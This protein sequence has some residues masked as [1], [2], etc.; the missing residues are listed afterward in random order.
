M[1]SNESA[2][3]HASK[4]N[5]RAAAVQ[6]AHNWREARSEQAERQ[7]FWNAFFQIFGVDRRQVAAFER[8]AERASTGN[9]GWI[10]MLNPGQMAVEHKSAGEDLDDAMG[11]L[12]DYLPSLTKAEMPWLLVVCDFQRF[13]WENLDTGEQGQFSL[14][15]LPEHLDLF[16]WIGGYNRPHQQFGSDEEANLAATQ[17]LANVHD[18]LAE[19]GYPAED[20]REWMTRVLFVLFADDSGVWDRAAFHTYIALH[21]KPDGSDLGQ[22]IA[23]IFE[24]LNTPPDRRQKNLD[25]DLAALTYVNGDI[26]AKRL[27][28]PICDKDTRDALLWAS[29][30]NWSVISPAIFGSLFQNVMEP[31]ERRQLGAHYTTEENILRTIRPLFLDALEAD[32]RAAKTK[33]ALRRFVDRLGEIHMLDPACGCGNFLVIAYRELRRLETEALRR[34]RQRDR[35]DQHQ[36]QTDVTLDLRVTVDQ[37]SGIELEE[38]P[39][40]IARTA[41]Y[42]ADHV[43]NRE[44]S[45][46]FGQHVLR[47]PIPASPHI[48]IGNALEMDWN[49]VLPA[50]RC[51]FV[52]GNPPFGGHT[53]RTKKQSDELRSVWGSGY[54]KWLDYVTGWYRKGVDYDSNRRIK[55]GYV[56]TNSISQGEQVARLWQPLLDSGYQIDWAHQ[57]IAWTSEA[58]GK[59]NVHVVIVGF[60]HDGGNAPRL[61]TYSTP[62]SP[63]VEVAAK[64]ISPYLVVGPDVA[65]AGRTEPVSSA[66][67]EAKYG[68]LPS[69]GGGLVVKPDAY[70]RGD[71]VAVKYLRPYYGSNE[72]VKG[73]ERWVIWMPDGPE[74]GDL[75]RSDFLRSRLEDVRRSRLESRNPDTQA[76]AEQPYKWFHNAQ[77]TTNYIGIP[78][79]VSETRRW[80]TVAHLTPDVIASNTLYTAEDPTGFL[81]AVLSSTMF[82]TWCGAIGGRLESRYR[83]AKSIVHNTFPLP[84]DFS[85][86]D[87]AAIVQGGKK[88]LAAR[89]KHPGVSLADLYEPL[90]TPPDVVKAHEAIDKAV[91]R[92]FDSRKRKWDHDSRMEHMLDRYVKA[93]SAG[94]LA[95]PP[96]GTT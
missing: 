64:N 33:P 94:R 24:V 69:D 58:R 32:L 90:A 31:A 60:S 30:F 11:Q 61:F 63:A 8:L 13:K 70:P 68:S 62:T 66:M 82:V 1:T 95:P 52:L 80:Y 50:D 34:L 22:T 10:D 89:A 57:T 17:L 84:D 23:L 44:L 71:A 7:S 76:L 51:D 42:L 72:L 26:F 28:I 41:L 56:S 86:G 74:P 21:T 49:D 12:I 27:A 92:L 93:I 59:A 48:E 78:A 39:A 75:R 37:F 19:H 35:K 6:F 87:R 77:P 3:A 29:V 4:A 81:F 47:F 9:R 38:F 85:K 16:W 53:T 91:D 83:Y 15:E 79:Q 40:K 43:A 18:Q 14:S 45:A 88:L 25:E 20:L 67:P 96:D 36:L 55:F 73:L 5:I 46:E 54:A 65:V 2:T